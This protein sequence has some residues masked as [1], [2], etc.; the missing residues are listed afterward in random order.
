MTT[1]KIA[2]QTVRFRDVSDENSSITSVR[3]GSLSAFVNSKNAKFSYRPEPGDAGDDWP[4]VSIRFP[5]ELRLTDDKGR[6][7][8]LDDTYAYIG[9][10][11]YAGR[12]STFLFIEEE[13]SDIVYDG[14]LIRLAGD[15]LP[16]FKTISDATNFL[17]SASLDRVSSG[18]FAPGR[19]IAFSSIPNRQITEN[20]RLVGTAGRDLLSGGKGNDVLIGK[21]GNDVLNGGTGNDRLDGGAGNDI[22]RGG[23]GR[24]TLVGGTGKDT[25]DG[26]TGKDIL[27]GGKGVDTFVFRTAQD[28]TPGRNHDIITD[29]SRGDKIDLSAID[30]NIRVR[31]SQ[32]FDF[33]GTK[34]E[35]NSVWFVRQADKV[36]LRADTNGDTRAD[37]EVELTGITRLIE[38]D[39]IF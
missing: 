18:A 3:S 32:D 20:D 22:L 27:T 35:A 29:F 31:G 1:I 28:S 12:K 6:I 34:A 36:I 10:A 23:S 7:L 33:S 4:D 15:A 38:S 30:A 17:S 14:Y 24:D 9:T 13:I 21:G 39:F 2:A 37:F 11:T 26:G 19:D 25:L 5:S 8:D 16:V